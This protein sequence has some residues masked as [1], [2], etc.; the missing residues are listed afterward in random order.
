MTVYKHQDTT[1]QREFENVYKLLE[2]IQK[3]QQALQEAVDKLQANID[4][5]INGNV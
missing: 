2:T 4:E 5:V 3:F 1:T